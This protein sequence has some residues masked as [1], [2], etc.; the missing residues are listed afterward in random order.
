LRLSQNHI[1]DYH[2]FNIALPEGLSSDVLLAFLGQLPFDTFEETDNG[3]QAYIPAAALDAD[4]KAAFAELQKDFGFTYEQKHIPAQNWNELWEANFD[5]IRV[6]GFC[7]VRATFHA[8]LGD[9]AHEVVI[10]PEMAFGTGHHETTYMMMHNMQPLDFKGKKVF[11]FGCGTGVLA[12][13][14]LKLGAASAL[15]LDHELPAYENTLLNAFL[16][17]TGNIEARCGTLADAPETGFGIILANI[18]RNV[19]LESLPEL[20]TKLN[21]GGKLL[22][23]GFLAQD[24]PLLDASA[25]K[26]GFR[27]LSSQQRG[28]W[29]CSL[30]E[31]NG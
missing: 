30:F 16:N 11:D 22:V 31:K 17:N 2:Q 1:M 4:T 24:G 12:I 25:Q 3:L 10:S 18:N 26:E 29:I 21:N 7:G 27:L 14:A 19:I 6:E 28:K 5:P 23:S 8:P 15:A 9:V 13:L 20:W